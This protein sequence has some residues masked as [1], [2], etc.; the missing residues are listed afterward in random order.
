LNNKPVGWTMNME[1]CLQELREHP[2][3]PGDSVLVVLAQLLK[4]TADL[5]EIST[6]RQIEAPSPQTQQPR[7]LYV[8]S[9]RVVLDK[10][11]SSAP[12]E[13]L[14]NSK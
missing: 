5:H 11:K 13:I 7:A 1:S 14:G 3:V 12:P 4:L 6:W 2:E 9:L 10:I 8:K